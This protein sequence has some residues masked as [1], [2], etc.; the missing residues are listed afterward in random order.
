MNVK[1]GLIR[2]AFMINE[3]AKV[4]ISGGVNHRDTKGAEEL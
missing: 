1:Q 4:G 3:S 2:S